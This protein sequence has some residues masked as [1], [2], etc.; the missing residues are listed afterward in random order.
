[1]LGDMAHVR[2][3]SATEWAEA[4]SNAFVPLRVRTPATRFAATLDRVE[5]T[6]SVSITR[7]ASD[8]SEVV[9]SATTIA[10]H[11]RDD[12]LL[13][14]HRIGSGRV[15]QH[16]REAILSRGRAS[17]YDASAPYTLSFPGRMSEIVLQVP[18]GT[19]PTTG[20]SFADITA[21]ALPP[22]TSLL[23]LQN[24]LLSVDPQVPPRTGSMENEMLADAATTLLRAALLPL[25]SRT[26]LRLEGHALAVAMRSYIDDNLTDPTL[27]VENLG[28]AL[29]VS[30]RQVYKVFAEHLNESP[31]T[32]IR[33]TR[34]RRAHN[35]LSAGLSVL[36]S[37]ITSGFADPDTFTRAFK[38][39]YGFP[40]SALKR[41][42]Q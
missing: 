27:T 39:H 25:E 4:C 32:Y 10:H 1:M 42:H 13:S 20:H 19:V 18:R 3:Q 23:A 5:L 41:M 8:G 9:R 21:S 30:V 40:P 35:E 2:A 33:R 12:L 29:H 26:P 22:S 31:G 36:Q 16:D 17:L 37:A 7:V 15:L 34:L 24:L 11:P 28:R 14:I 6:S 38:R